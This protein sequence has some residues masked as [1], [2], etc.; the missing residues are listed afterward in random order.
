MT[1]EE[2]I[3]QCILLDMT[4]SKPI[5]LLSHDYYT[6]A[7]TYM[8]TYWGLIPYGVRQAL[9]KSGSIFWTEDEVKAAKQRALNREIY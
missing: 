5:Y 3:E 7:L 1:D 6:Y 8:Q 2:V 4:P 9:V